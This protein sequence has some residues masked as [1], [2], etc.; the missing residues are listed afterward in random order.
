MIA[1]KIL[2]KTYEEAN[3]RRKQN[4][5]FESNPKRFYRKLGKQKWNVSTPPENEKL[6]KFWKGIFEYQKEHNKEAE[7]IPQLVH[8]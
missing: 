3:N 7:W 5:M 6:E 4:H 2:K 8:T 1:R